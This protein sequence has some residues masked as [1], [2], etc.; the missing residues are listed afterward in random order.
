MIN[1]LIQKALEPILRTQNNSIAYEAIHAL[2]H[3]ISCVASPLDSSPVLS[4]TYASRLAS[5]IL[6]ELRRIRDLDTT[7]QSDQNIFS[8]ETIRALSVLLS[9]ICD[10]EL[11][12]AASSGIRRTGPVAFT[13][14]MS[15]KQRRMS[16]DVASEY[17]ARSISSFFDAVYHNRP[18]QVLE[19]ALRDVHFSIKHSPIMRVMET[20]KKSTMPNAQAGADLKSVV[21]AY[22]DR[23][24][25]RKYRYFEYL[26]TGGLDDRLANKGMTGPF[27]IF[28]KDTQQTSIPI[29]GNEGLFWFSTLPGEPKVSELGS[30]TPTKDEKSITQD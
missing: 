18:Q 7:W 19:E 5:T 27:A 24:K 14:D 21:I 15:M 6:D 9:S 4:S 1:N 22:C 17:V 23:I 20:K 30:E 29:L 28:L 10:R 2:I 16:S 8:D 11:R 26:Q 12:I 25:Q 13:D 3:H